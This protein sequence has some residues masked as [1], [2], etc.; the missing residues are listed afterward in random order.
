MNTLAEAL[1][2]GAYHPASGRQSELYDANRALYGRVIKH[3]FDTL[4]APSPER[5]IAVRKAHEWLM[6]LNA[7]VAITGTGADSG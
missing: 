6:A 4:P 3:I 2:L 1:N 7:A 5:T